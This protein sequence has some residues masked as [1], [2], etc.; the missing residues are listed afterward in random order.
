MRWIRLF[1]QSRSRQNVEFAGVSENTFPNTRLPKSID[2]RAP[3]PGG[4]GRNLLN[5]LNKS[6]SVASL[7]EWP[8]AC[9]NSADFPEKLKTGIRP[10]LECLPRFTRLPFWNVTNAV[11]D[12]DA[13]VFEANA[14]AKNGWR[15]RLNRTSRP[16][17][18]EEVCMR[19]IRLQGMSIVLAAAMVFGFFIAMQPQT[20]YSQET[21]GGLQGTVKDPSG[22]L[23]SKAKVV[24]TGANMIG[25]KVLTT[26]SSG[27]FHFTNLPPGTYTLTVSAQGFQT[28]KRSGLGIDVGRL[29]NLDIAL[30]VGSEATTVQ[31]T[32]EAP[33]IDTTTTQNMTNINTAALQNLPTGYSFQ[34]L[35]QM[36]P[37]AR[38]E[39]LS[40]MQQNGHSLGGSGGAMPGSSGNGQS[41]G[42][43]IGGA[44]DSESSYLVDG[45]DTENISGGF[46]KA[47]V[48]MDFIASEDIKTSGVQAEYGGALGGVI[49]VTTKTGGNDFHGEILSYYESSST[50]A[51]P[52]TAYLRYDPNGPPA[53]NI[54]PNSQLYQAKKDHFRTVEPGIIVQG[55][56]RKDHY[57]FTLGFEPMVNSTARTVDFSPSYSSDPTLGQQYFTRDRQQYFGMARIDAA[58]SQKVRVYFKWLPEYARET[59]ASLPTG[60]PIHQQSGIINSAVLSP[61]SQYFH[62]IGWSAP[63]D[64]YNVGADWTIS[65]R[66]VSTT[67]YGYFF[68]NYHDFGW[69]TTTPDLNW[70]TS[71][72][73][74]SDNKTPLPSSLQQP[75]GF[76]TTAY[77]SS[78][79][80][81]NA[82]KHYQFDQ[83]FT[84]TK[85]GW[86]GSHTFQFGYQLNHLVNSIS[87]NGNVPYAYMELGQHGYN[88]L[89][90]TGAANCAK[91][92]NEWGKCTGQYGYLTVQDFSTILTAPASDYNHALYIQDS[93]NLGKGLTLDVGLR[94][95]KESLPAPAGVKIPAINFPWSDKIE[96][97]LGAAWDP[98]GT[99]K[100]KIYGFYGVVND[101]MK[102]L[103]A[104]TSWGAQSY[105]LCTYAL[106]PDGGPN[107]FSVSD[108]NIVFKNGRACPNGPATTQ[109]NFG[110][111]VPA[112]LTDSGSGVSLIE[113]VNERPMEPVAPNVKPYR[114]HEYVA[115]VEYELSPRLMLHARYDRR[116]LDHAI[117]DASLSDVNWG[118]TYAIVNP[119]EGVNST[120]DGYANY[121]QSL[122]QSFGVPG[123]QFDATAFGSCPN[124]PA[125]PKAV[126]NYDEFNIG[127]HLANLGRFT[128]D[129]NYLYSSLWGNYPGLTT[130]D[131]TDG[132]ITGRNSPD[133]TRAFD[134]PYYY[135]GANGK[136]TD[137]PMPTDRPNVL[138]GDM[139]YTLPWRHQETS[140][141]IF[142]QFLQGSPQSSYIDVGAGSNAGEPYEATYV[143]G[144][145]QWVNYSMNPSTGAISM[146]TP[147]SFRSPWF[148]Q[149]D[150]N[151][152]QAFHVGEGKTIEFEA[153]ATNAF[154]QRAITS[155]WGMMDSQYSSSGIFPGGQSIY[156]GAAAYNAYEHP[157]NVQQ[158]ATS[159][160]VVGN[161][162]YNQPY[163]YQLGRQLRFSLRYTF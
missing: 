121:L 90:Q 113:N 159:Q 161:S 72:S 7:G 74:A 122:G 132:G 6:L 105:E 57:W 146:G 36:A 63:M 15:S 114:Q 52:V 134:E 93:W 153:D 61:I 127:M 49:N 41:F 94:I 120:I 78:Y 102:L 104:Q 87:Q 53:G 140:F 89:T 59:G 47:N 162:T 22:L 71:G 11:H 20:S 18:L 40:G 117:E 37:M 24:V 46:S 160:A 10:R 82:D 34:S 25:S 139:Y 110:G 156:S 81:L 42:Y 129:V 149:T 158:L 43:M 76:S 39:P 136:S 69:P 2:S 67:R 119:G 147:H 21:T 91:L 4:K 116:R 80:I 9:S 155:Y 97:R 126:R 73:V 51:N 88:P 143:F 107:G 109:A 157:Y 13:T 5:K 26:D 28:Y 23:V 137:G 112:S 98:T 142:Q 1:A 70:Y 68:D 135:F 64:T 86:W 103:V 38:Q 27:Y 95:E 124:C 123:W 133:T 65:N 12:L 148:I 151:A 85:G 144:R 138:K 58:L 131:Q 163:L 56:I 35:I 125:N 60:D 145:D 130:T 50:D 62:G 14:P 108:I 115:G 106:G 83:D 54:E 30:Q 154:N 96:P 17:V 79:T 48:P 152:S 8:H 99:G 33:I 101:V 75:A 111:P 77:N 118:E 16:A 128:G 45:Q 3:A 29:P 32:G 150:L 31:V 141:G 84:F 44:A 55:P 92:T 100:M 19:L 66:F